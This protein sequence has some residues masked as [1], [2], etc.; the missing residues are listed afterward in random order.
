[1][2]VAA[3]DDSSQYSWQVKAEAVNCEM[4]QNNPVSDILKKD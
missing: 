2:T 1:M 3:V 4:F